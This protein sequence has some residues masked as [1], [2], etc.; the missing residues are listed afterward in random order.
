MNGVDKSVMALFI[1]GHRLWPNWRQFY[2]GQAQCISY[3]T[4][5]RSAGDVRP[6]LIRLVINVCLGRR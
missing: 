3:L 2:L 5:R 6:L 4:F 1:G